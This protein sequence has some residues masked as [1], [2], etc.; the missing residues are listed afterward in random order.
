[1]MIGMKRIAAAGSVRMAAPRTR[2]MTDAPSATG[3]VADHDDGHGAERDTEP[4][5]VAEQVAAEEFVGCAKAS[6]SAINAE[7]DADDQRSLAD[8][9]D[10]RRRPRDRVV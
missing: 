5:H 3:Q 1:M 4:V 8:R 2:R 9:L 7:D 10:D 6:A